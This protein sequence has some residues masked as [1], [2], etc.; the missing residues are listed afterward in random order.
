M[1]P[2]MTMVEVGYLKYVGEQ[3]SQH[4]ALLRVA[5]AAK[6]IKDENIFTGKRSAYTELSEALKEVEHLL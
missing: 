3:A 1:E 4:A 2:K 6:T 5:R